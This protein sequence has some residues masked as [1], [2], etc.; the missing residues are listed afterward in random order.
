MKHPRRSLRALAAVLA[1]PD[2]VPELAGLVGDAAVVYDVG[3]FRG[4]VA[5]RLLRV[6]PAATVH[7]FEPHPVTRSELERRAAGLDRLVVVPAGAGASAGTARLHIGPLP[8]TASLLD[9]P[10]GGP[11]YYPP[12]A[13]LDEVVEVEVV[14]L[15]E[16]AAA[17]G[18]WPEALK[19]DVQGGELDVL[20]GADRCLRESV[21]GILCELQFVP[22]YEGAPRFDEVARHLAERGFRLYR[23]YDLHHAGDGQLIFGDAVFV[24]NDL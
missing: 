19:L 5:E 16:Y 11:A 6:F 8:A 18:A 24:R 2:P 9:R 22:L 3:A 21:R 12:D 13:V 7:A 10:S 20:R 17:A 14:T 1:P 23:F 15:D 4:G